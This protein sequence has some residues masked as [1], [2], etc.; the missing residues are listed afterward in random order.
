MKLL[1]ENFGPIRKA[2]VELGPMTVFV[3]PSNAGKSYLAILIYS[4]LSTAHDHTYGHLLGDRYFSD[5]IDTSASS[6]EKSLDAREFLFRRI[7]ESFMAWAVRFSLV[8]MRRMEDCFLDAEMPL[9]MKM[10]KSVKIFSGNKKS[11]EKLV[12]DLSSPGKSNLPESQ[13]QAVFEKILRFP[14]VL[15][16]LGEDSVEDIARQMKTGL[17]RGTFADRL[18]PILSSMLLGSVSGHPPMPAHYLPTA[19]S[20]LMQ[21][22]RSQIVLTLGSRRQDP[23]RNL[24]YP[25]F[26]VD[27]LKKLLYSNKG[28]SYRGALYVGAFEGTEQ[29]KMSIARAGMFVE[30]KIMRGKLEAVEMHGGY[31]EFDYVF[32]DESTRDRVP[33]LHASSMVA[34]L[35]ALVVF[36]REHIYPGDLLIF[37]EPEAGLHPAAQRDITN[38]LVQL[39]N[40]GVHVLI[41]TH[42]DTILEQINNAVVASEVEEKIAKQKLAEENL[43]TYLFKM[44][45]D[46]KK[47]AAVKK[48]HFDDEVGILTKDHLDVSTALYNESV[49]LFNAGEKA[50]GKS[51]KKGKKNVD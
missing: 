9:W 29:Q 1:V 3:G 8:W 19:R 15:Q 45:K 13:K 38:A 40:A 41:T 4:I 46:I 51:G 12:L 11:E 44:P 21:N 24:H 42:S 31:P 6:K 47:G 16:L 37:E 17:M 43:S 39:A 2:E 7:E 49:R 32:G 35:A 18:T 48:I 27:F 25:L 33:L 14:E 30:S 36:I 10:G 22:L 23:G 26:I 34:E 28:E 5:W 20:F 50:R